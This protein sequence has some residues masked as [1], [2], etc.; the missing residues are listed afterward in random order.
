M[1]YVND[2]SQGIWRSLNNGVT[3]TQIK[4]PLDATQSTD[5]AEF[6]VTTRP[7]ATRGCTS[8]SATP[9]PPPPAYNGYDLNTRRGRDTCSR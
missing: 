1:I 2:F 7:T 6:D 5:R 4:T 9:D 3:W 8:A